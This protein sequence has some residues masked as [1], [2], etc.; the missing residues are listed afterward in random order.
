MI[1]S[2]SDAVRTIG[3][4]LLGQ[5]PD[6]RLLD[7]RE[8]LLH[9]STHAQAELRAAVRPIVA[10]LARTYRDFGAVLVLAY[11]DALLRRDLAEGVGAFLVAVLRE[12]LRDQLRAVD[13]HRTWRLVNSKR[14]EAQE[15]GACS[16]PSSRRSGSR[17]SRS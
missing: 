7:Y 4:R 6:H 9:L 1:D 11:A 14:A 12:D 16:W 2:S 10:R 13:E 3:V 8:T 17:S 15:L 5:L